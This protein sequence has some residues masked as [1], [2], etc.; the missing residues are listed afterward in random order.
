MNHDRRYFNNCNKGELDTKNEQNLNNP[1]SF[2]NFNNNIPHEMDISLNDI[3]NVD[4]SKNNL[5]AESKQEDGKNFTDKNSE[6]LDQI[7]D[8]SFDQKS[9]TYSLLYSDTSEIKENSHIFQNIGVIFIKVHQDEVIENYNDFK[10][11]IKFN[12]NA[13]QSINV[14][15]KIENIDMENEIIFNGIDIDD[16]F[17]VEQFCLEELLNDESTKKINTCS[18]E[19]DEKGDFKMKYSFNKNDYEK[20][21]KIIKSFLE[22]KEGKLEKCNNKDFE[23]LKETNFEAKENL[24]ENLE[25]VKVKEISEKIKSNKNEKSE[26]SDSNKKELNNTETHKNIFHIKKKNKSFNKTDYF[27][28][29]KVLEDKSNSST[30][31]SLSSNNASNTS[32]KSQVFVDVC[33]CD[34]TVNHSNL[35]YGCKDIDNLFCDITFVENKKKIFNITKVFKAKSKFNKSYMPKN[36]FAINQESEILQNKNISLIFDS[37][38]NKIE[39]VHNNLSANNIEHI[40]DETDES[41]EEFLKSKRKRFKKLIKSEMRTLY[42][43]E[44][45]IYREFASYLSDNEEKYKNTPSLDDEFWKIIHIKD[46]SK[47]NKEFEGK[48]I[49]SFSHKLIKYIFSKDISNIYENFLKD[50]DFHKNYISQNKKRTE[51]KNNNS[52][53]L[54][55]KNIHKIYCKKYKESEFELNQS[56]IS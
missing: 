12:N 46:I 6:T 40:Q 50:K 56:K 51:Y 44:K 17:I 16:S 42:D 28:K 27:N 8:I 2:L 14:D 15:F 10:E 22:R 18:N 41:W 52:Y 21:K 26:I 31:V 32:F 53:Q 43:F 29:V 35:F 11:G 9:D 3:N 4:I 37:R 23:N 19:K 7:D 38:I 39:N 48:K 45:N 36:D 49:K 20:A 5:D 25:K 54:Y 13:N 1:F 24:N 33:L 34:Q 30:K 47:S 55:K